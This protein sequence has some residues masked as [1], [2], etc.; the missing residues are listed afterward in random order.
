MGIFILVLLA[1]WLILA[2]LGFVVKGLIWLAI[3]AGVLF[4]AT[5]IFGWF[6]RQT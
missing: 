1:L 5:A 2:I 3:V 4:I 6:K